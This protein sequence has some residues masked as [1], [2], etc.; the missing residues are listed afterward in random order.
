MYP[1]QDLASLVERA[2]RNHSTAVGVVDGDRQLTFGMLEDRTARLANSLLSVVPA[3]QSRVAV[4]MANSAEFIEADIA[5]LRAGLA[6][7]PINPR[8]S[9]DERRHILA[10]SGA[11][12]VVVDSP[13]LDSIMTLK[14]E[15][16]TIASTIVVGGSGDQDYESVLAAA[17]PRLSR[18]GPRAHDPSVILYTSGTTGRPKGAIAT[19]ASRLAAVLNMLASEVSAQRGDSILHAGPLSH[20]SGSKVIP[21]LLKGARNIVT[22]KFEPAQF[23]ALAGRVGAT[24]T[25]VVPTMI[26]MLTEAVDS[27]SVPP[28]FLNRVSYGGAPI[29]E[30][31][32]V[33]AIDR[34][35]SIFT[36]VY[37][38]CEAPH[39]V[40]V[41]SAADH[42]VGLNERSLLGS[43]GRESLGMSIRVVAD[44]GTDVADGEVGEVL[45]G[46][47]G[48]MVGYWNDA[49]A[50][51]QS[52][53]DGWYWSGD[54][55]WRDNAGFLHLVDRKRGLIISGGM[56]IYPSEIERVL[57]A[58]PDVAEAAVV[59]VPDEKWGESVHA[60]VVP[61]N[62]ATILE[63]ALIAHCRTLL[64]SYKKPRFVTVVDALPRGST[65][66]VD[67][68]VLRVR[69]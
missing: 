32:I 27:G 26:A 4:L 45:I 33:E 6:K 3:P 35:G 34:F 15:L 61:R 67:K 49:E 54:L 53:R 43:A 10:D 5:I 47:A 30:R 60:Y 59:G 58:H 66:K 51:Q 21:F 14:E 9:Q 38:S 20:G 8:L 7:V 65:G 36:Q 57:M 11:A 22:P 37:G 31:T 46:G 29:A 25:F 18:Q 1:H 12:V 64:A 50:T 13:N 42:L 52:L 63:E 40:T 24:S 44:D 19:Y 68:E 48:L 23:L 56:N 16:G 69:T 55:G 39:P 2:L 62:G 28:P 41:L 17:S